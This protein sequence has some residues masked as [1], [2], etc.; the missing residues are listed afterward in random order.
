MSDLKNTNILVVDDE[1]DITD[2]IKDILEDEGFTV[3]T[4][5]NGTSAQKL[6][7]IASLI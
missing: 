6:F 7:K 2:L 1:E 4:A 3:R 5:S